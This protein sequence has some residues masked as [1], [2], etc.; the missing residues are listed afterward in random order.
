MYPITP[1]LKTWRFIVVFVAMVLIALVPD[2]SRSYCQTLP[3]TPT[4]DTELREPRIILPVCNCEETVSI[5]DPII[6]RLRWG[7]KTQ[8]LTEQG[9]DFV[10]Y[11]LSVDGRFIEG[12]D[13]YRKPAV[14]VPRSAD[15]EDVWWVYWDYPLG[16]LPAG[17]HIIEAVF[18]PTA[19]IFDGWWTFPKGE[20]VTLQVN[21]HV[22]GPSQSEYIYLSELQPQSSKVGWGA[23]SIG[24]YEFTSPD[25]THKISKGD[26]IVVHKVEYHHGLY[27]YA[28]SQLVYNLQGDFSQ[29]EVTIGLVDWIDCGDGVRFIIL[30]DGNVIYRSPT[31]FASS[32]PRDVKISVVGGHELVFIT[33]PCSTSHCDWAIWGDPTL[34]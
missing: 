21:L 25:P 15:D 24:T 28:P 16:T 3:A 13:E 1:I 29:L 5:D 2:A 8:E 7:A 34:R 12:L 10:A 17:D 31:M 4:T 32:T 30:L 18:V 23:F 19:T 14:F 20:S 26:P 33:D 27:A 11:T 6:V 22:K 9:A